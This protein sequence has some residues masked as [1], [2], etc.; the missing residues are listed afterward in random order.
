MPSLSLTVV[1][2]IE[3]VGKGELSVM[4]PMAVWSPILS[5][6]VSGVS[7]SVSVIAGTLT[8]K[9]ETPGGT[10]S[11]PPARV[12]PLVKVALV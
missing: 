9:L 3:S 4:V 1:S 5:G 8:L 2:L 12:T 6:T 10:V 7:F 11:T